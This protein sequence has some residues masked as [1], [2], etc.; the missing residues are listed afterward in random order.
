[1][2]SI[3]IVIL[4]L[5]CLSASAIT[6]AWENVPQADG[7]AFYAIRAKDSE[8]LRFDVG[9]NLTLNAALS[10]GDWI[11]FVRSYSTNNSNDV[12]VESVAGNEVRFYIP[13][14]VSGFEVH[15][16]H[17]FEVPIFQLSSNPLM[18]VTVFLQRSELIFPPLWSEGVPLISYDLGDSTN[19]QYRTRLETRKLQ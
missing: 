2:K 10:P 7:F 13:D 3:A 17:P 9:T 14:P 19:S 5:S 12:Q 16:D 15:V 18:R 4:L 8:T 11:A 6:F 1:M